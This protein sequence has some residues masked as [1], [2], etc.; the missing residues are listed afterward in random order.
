MQIAVFDAAADGQTP[1]KAARMAGSSATLFVDFQTLR[2]VFL[3]FERWQEVVKTLQLE[4][5]GIDGSSSVSLAPTR[6]RAQRRGSILTSL[7]GLK[8]TARRGSVLATLRG[9][10]VPALGAAPGHPPVRGSRRVSSAFMAS[11]L[12]VSASRTSRGGLDAPPPPGGLLA[13][14]TPTCDAIS[15]SSP[16]PGGGEGEEVSTHDPPKKK[17]RVLR[18]ACKYGCKALCL[19]VWLP[20]KALKILWRVFGKNLVKFIKAFL[21][22]DFDSKRGRAFLG[23]YVP[24]CATFMRCTWNGYVGVLHSVRFWKVFPWVF[25]V[26]TILVSK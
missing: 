15:E 17:Y 14:G 11:R 7:R 3:A 5:T 6:S 20:L 22:F 24:G 8:G 23:K 21:K 2:A 26:L 16:L 13:L 18:L 25:S 9:G 12:S 1:A 10:R 19:P 4:S